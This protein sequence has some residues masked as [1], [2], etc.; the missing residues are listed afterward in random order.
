MMIYKKKNGRTSGIASYADILWVRQVV[1]LPQQRGEGRMSAQEATPDIKP[2][3]FI[4]HHSDLRMVCFSGSTVEIAT[5]VLLH[6]IK[7]CEIWDQ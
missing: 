4:N 6:G 2:F 7:V 1:F 5:Q 3:L